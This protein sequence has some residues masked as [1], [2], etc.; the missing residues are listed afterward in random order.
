ML[1]IYLKSCGIIFLLILIF[2]GMIRLL[3]HNTPYFELMRRTLLPNE[4]CPAPCIMGIRAGETKPVDALVNLQS[5]IWVADA[6]F[7][8]QPTSNE[9]V[10]E[11]RL[12]WE[13]NFSQPAFL[14]WQGYARFNSQD[15]VDFIELPTAITFGEIIVAFG[16]P[17]RA[18]IGNVY[19]YAWYPD[20]G[21]YIRTRK[22]CDNILAAYVTIFY[23]DWEPPTDD[24]SNE[25][26]RE[27][28][29]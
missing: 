8:T 3:S 28:S 15:T 5:H 9:Y 1:R 20:Y 27:Q 2:T 25:F 21:L 23:M 4:S 14:P 10:A 11:T 29:C 12:N 22:G 7:E 17:E 18:R 19:H 24:Y 26:V 16:Y 13:W 6:Y